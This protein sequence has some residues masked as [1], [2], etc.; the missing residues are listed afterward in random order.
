MLSSCQTESGTKWLQVLLCFVETGGI[1]FK[2]KSSQNVAS[3]NEINLHGI[4]KNPFWCVH[5]CFFAANCNGFEKRKPEIWPQRPRYFA[6]A[7]A[8]NY[9]RGVA[10]PW[11]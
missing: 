9:A 4:H 2:K 8:M 6:A 11:G 10:Y 3:E 7:I 1:S 5:F